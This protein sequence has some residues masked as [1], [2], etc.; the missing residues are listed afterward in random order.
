MDASDKISTYCLYVLCGYVLIMHPNFI[1]LDNVMLFPLLILGIKKII[2]DKKIWLYVLT[3]FLN[4]IICYQI[5][6]MVLFSIISCMII[7]LLLKVEKAERKQIAFLLG[8]GT[9][10]ALL[11][12]SFLLVPSLTQALNSDRLT[13]GNIGDSL[14]SGNLMYKISFLLLSPIALFGYISLH[15]YIKKD[16]KNIICL[17]LMLLVTGIIQIIFERANMIWHGGSYL[18]FGFRFGF[19]PIFVLL[20]G[21]IYYFS[22]YNKEDSSSK[23][24]IN[25]RLIINLILY[26]AVFIITVL[27]MFHLIP[28]INY[29][30]PNTELYEDGFLM[31]IEIN[32]LIIFAFMIA[33]NMKSKILERI[34]IILIFIA[35]L[36]TFCFCYIGVSPEYRGGKEWSDEGLEIA[37]SL[38]RDF[39]LENDN[40]LYRYRDS[41]RTLNVNYPLITKT[42]SISSWLHLISRKSKTCL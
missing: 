31:L 28:I 29:N 35:S 30:I 39:N 22:K 37:N 27:E 25:K 14:D 19:I 8:I 36:I 7:Y 20:N 24:V 42:P 13:E 23:I 32:M 2:D 12:S 38:V 41:E 40:S 9:L 33:L 21:G 3:L 11:L 10:L 17:D 18:S 6:Y 26:I 34:L 1:W 15:N 16:S 4:L 5:A